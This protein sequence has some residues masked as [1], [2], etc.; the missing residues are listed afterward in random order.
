M[1]FGVSKQELDV[2]IPSIGLTPIS[3]DPEC[4]VKHRDGKLVLIIA[5][6]VDDLKIAGEEA[7]AEVR[8]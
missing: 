1:F 5:K 7:E 2:S 6:H 8:R 4:E 3:T